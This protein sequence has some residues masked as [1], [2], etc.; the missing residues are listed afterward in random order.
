MH[1]DT[2]HIHPHTHTYIYMKML[3]ENKN[4]HTHTNLTH[5]KHNYFTIQEWNTRET[6]YN[7]VSVCQTYFQWINDDND[8]KMSN[9]QTSIIK[10]IFKKKK[11]NEK[12]KDKTIIAS[13]Q[14]VAFLALSW[15]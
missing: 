1:I 7:R 4:T 14:L 6:V 15:Y 13:K 8:I 2:F 10:T 5:S 9:M 11:K 12:K 3:E